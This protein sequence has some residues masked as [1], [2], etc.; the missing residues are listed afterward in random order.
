MHISEHFEDELETGPAIM[1]ELA[2]LAN[3]VLRGKGHTSEAEI[4]KTQ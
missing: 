3:S 2:K 4:Q 1:P